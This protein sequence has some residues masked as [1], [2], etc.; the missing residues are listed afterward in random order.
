MC[1]RTWLTMPPQRHSYAW[2][3]AS[4][5][6]TPHSLTLALTLTLTL[7]PILTLTLTLTPVLTLTPTLLL[8]DPYTIPRHAAAHG[9]S[10]EGNPSGGN[11]YRGLYNIALKS[12][13]AAMKRHPDVRL[14][15]VLE[16]AP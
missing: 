5:G 9:C 15:H 16:C 14:E 3:T 11:M 6:V 10:A 1:C 7:T 2:S 4:R 12:L 8:P 13:G